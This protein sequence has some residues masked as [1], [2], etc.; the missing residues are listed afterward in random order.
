MVSCAIYIPRKL[1]MQFD[2]TD[3]ASMEAK[4]LSRKCGD[5]FL[6]SNSISCFVVEEITSKNFK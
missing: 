4:L 2:E 6:P 5:L 1:L 3:S